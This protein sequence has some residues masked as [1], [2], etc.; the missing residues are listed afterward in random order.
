MTR[1]PHDT[2]AAP[3][4]RAVNSSPQV[5]S[6]ATSQV[7]RRLALALGGAG[8]LA[9]SSRAGAQTGPGGYPARPIR[10]MVGYPPGGGADLLGRIFAQ[11]AS[12]VLGQPVVVENRAGAGGT[13][14]AAALASAA[15]DGY[16]LYFAES[17]VLVAPAVYDRIG[18]DPLALAPVGSVGSLAYTIVLHPSVPARTVPELIALLKSNPGRYNYASPG[19]GNIAHLSAELFKKMAGVE[20]THL[21]YKGGTPALTDL[22]GGQVPICFVS[23]SPTLPLAKAGKLRLLAVTTAR[24]VPIAPDVPSIAETLA[25]FNAAASA[26][27][28]AP[29]GTPAA[30]TAHLNAALRKTMESPEVLAGFAQHGALVDTGSPDQLAAQIR[31]EVSTW[32]ATARAAGARAE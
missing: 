4:T 16:T 18:Y 19:V 27:V 14:A 11:R 29:P 22:V 20:M 32:G 31:D 3:S 7:R 30:I 10:L 24:R 15:S 23:I 6:P 8:W 2:D 21:P 17:A 1:D 12:Q 28:L 5:T 13:I 26:F 25:G 9:L